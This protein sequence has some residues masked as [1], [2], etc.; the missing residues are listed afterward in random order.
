[1]TYLVLFASFFAKRTITNYICVV[2]Y[3]IILTFVAVF[4]AIRT[5]I[6]GKCNCSALDCMRCIAHSRT[7]IVTSRQPVY[8]L[9][10]R[11]RQPWRCCGQ[12]SVNGCWEAA[13]HLAVKNVSVAASLF[14]I[15]AHTIPA[16]R[17]VHF[18]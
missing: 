14:S 4:I 2:I 11:L 18:V 5:L 3:N 1:M 15:C 17:T 8:G 16:C 9:W 13:H 6:V 12:R 10:N 7:A